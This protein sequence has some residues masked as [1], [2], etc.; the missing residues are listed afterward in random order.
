MI[1]IAPLDL[2]SLGAETAEW[3]TPF[4]SQ[5]EKGDWD[6]GGSWYDSD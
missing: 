6:W 2:D 4:T 3:F 5:A 1:D